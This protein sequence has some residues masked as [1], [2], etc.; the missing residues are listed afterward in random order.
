MATIEIGGPDP[1]PERT[2]FARQRLREV[3]GIQPFLEEVVPNS[4]DTIELKT[5]AKN[6]TLS[7]RPDGP[8][9]NIT[10]V[11]PPDDTTVGGQVIRII[12]TEDISDFWMTG[13]AHMVGTPTS[14]SAGDSFSFHKTSTNEWMKDT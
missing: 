10:V 12:T 2:L 7:L 14:L 4:G 1:A 6:G 9:S 11:L 3:L 8:V 13:T 5:G